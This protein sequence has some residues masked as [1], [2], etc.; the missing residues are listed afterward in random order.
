MYIYLCIRVH[1]FQYYVC[2]CFVEGEE[3]V[4][5]S[6]MNKVGATFHTQVYIL[7]M[8]YTVIV[9]V[10]VLLIFIFF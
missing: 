9:I 10:I 6:I 2:L 7:H 1:A 5:L 3:T 4:R 8:T